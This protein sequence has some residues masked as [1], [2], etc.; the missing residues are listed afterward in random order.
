[1]LKGVVRSE[2]L[3]CPE[4]Y[5]EG[6]LSKLKDLEIGRDKVSGTIPFSVYGL[7]NLEE[8]YL[9]QNLMSGTISEAIGEIGRA[10]CRE[11]V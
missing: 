5:I 11:R 6:L 9:K 3:D 10:S 7:Q 1:M 8:I 4:L 2:K